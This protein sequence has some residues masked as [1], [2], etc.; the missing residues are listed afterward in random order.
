MK[1]VEEEL[2]A[3]VDRAEGQKQGV[4]REIQQLKDL[5]R[6]LQTQR[7]KDNAQ[8]E[9]ASRVNRRTLEQLGEQLARKEAEVQE[10]RL[11]LAQLNDRETTRMR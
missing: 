4:L 1:G 2:R 7:E 9:E 6:A 3:L 5:E 8:F 10:L 11:A